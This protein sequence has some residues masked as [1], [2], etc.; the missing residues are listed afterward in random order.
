ML[1]STAAALAAAL[2][3]AA[4]MAPVASAAPI[5][6]GAANGDPRAREVAGTA[7]DTIARTRGGKPTGKGKA[8]LCS[9]LK[10]IRD[11][12]VEERNIAT[13]NQATEDA[14]KFGCGWAKKN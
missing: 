5:T 14:G 8:V 3:L 4:A 1:R 6:G 13:R 10:D 11:V 2:S 9:Q 7:G 12:A